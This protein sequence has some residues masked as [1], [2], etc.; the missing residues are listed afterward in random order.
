MSE[1]VFDQT[2]AHWSQVCAHPS[3][4]RFDSCRFTGWGLPADPSE[5]RPFRFSGFRFEECTFTDCDLSNIDVRNAA[6][7]SVKFVGCK[8]QGIRWDAAAPMGFACEWWQCNLNFSVFE[9]VDLRYSRF[10]DAEVK[11][12]DFSRSLC[13]SLRFENCVLS[14]A[15]WT[16]SDCT[17]ADFSASEGITMDPDEVRLGG[18]HFRHDQ[19]HGLLVK[20]GIQIVP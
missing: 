1:E 16:A 14:G 7:R 4:T 17:D 18:A 12:A 8:L 3:G 11:E 5:R 2:F 20:H 6:F 15:V 13:Q 10:V 19:L 9:G